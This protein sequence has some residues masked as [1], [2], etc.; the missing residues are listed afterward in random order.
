MA[1][2]LSPCFDSFWIASSCLSVTFLLRSPN[3]DDRDGVIAECSLCD[4][5]CFCRMTLAKLLRHSRECRHDVMGLLIPL[6]LIDLDHDALTILHALESKD[7][8][9]EIGPLEPFS[10][11]V[12]SAPS[13]LSAGKS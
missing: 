8:L 3:F 10:M 13:V 1:L 6:P 2:L 4:I 5:V 11:T 7:A 9:P 12:S